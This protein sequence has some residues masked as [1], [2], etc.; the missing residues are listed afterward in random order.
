MKRRPIII[1][2]IAL[3]LWLMAS[4]V[5]LYSQNNAYS[6]ALVMLF[7][8]WLSKNFI[9]LRWKDLFF[10]WLLLCIATLLA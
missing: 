9:H 10:S 1:H 7:L 2:A 3:F 8:Y 4:I 6:S 5:Y